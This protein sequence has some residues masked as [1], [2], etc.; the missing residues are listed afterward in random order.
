MTKLYKEAIH[1]LGMSYMGLPDEVEGVNKILDKANL[2]SKWGSES[3]EKNDFYQSF[4]AFMQVDD[5][6]LD[7]EVVMEKY[8]KMVSVFLEIMRIELKEVADVF[9]FLS[10]S[11]MRMELRGVNFPEELNGNISKFIQTEEEL[12][13]K[14][15]ELKGKLV[16]CELGDNFKDRRNELLEKL[17]AEKES[18]NKGIE[19]FYNR[20][21]E[22]ISE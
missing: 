2:Y 9:S 13:K 4:H 5:Q 21:K 17:D 15:D 19:A 1:Y 3:G 7:D 11:R 22:Y 20:I 6:L 8:E 16:E 14:S 10:E 12:Q 18:I